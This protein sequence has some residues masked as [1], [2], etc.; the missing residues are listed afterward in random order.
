MSRNK[1]KSDVKFLHDQRHVSISNNKKSIVEEY[2]IDGSKGLLVK[3][4]DKKGDKFTK[5]TIKSTDDG[6][7]RYIT[8]SDTKDREE[9]T[10]NKKD[11]LAI[12]KKN[13]N[14]DFAIDYITKQ[15][16]GDR[17]SII[18]TRSMSRSRPRRNMY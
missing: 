14:L 12:L 11:L 15:K 13:K 2:I 8:V 16:G 10:L 1:E 6:N 5:I 17:N 18:R 3:F 9:Q 7:Y 4:F